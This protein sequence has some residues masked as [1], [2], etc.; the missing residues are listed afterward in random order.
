MASQ[1]LLL[2]YTKVTDRNA[3]DI[4]IFRV[5]GEEGDIGDLTPV[6]VSVPTGDAPAPLP[7]PNPRTMQSE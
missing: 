6:Q 5:L 4:K 3:F 7:V 2:L 1:V